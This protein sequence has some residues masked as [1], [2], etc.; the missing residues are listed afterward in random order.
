MCNMDSIIQSSQQCDEEDITNLFLYRKGLNAVY[1]FGLCEGSSNGLPEAPQLV[2]H[3]L[4]YLP[5]LNTLPY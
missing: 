2:F 3:R 1:A 4:V 5:N